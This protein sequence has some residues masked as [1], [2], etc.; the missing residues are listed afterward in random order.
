MALGLVSRQPTQRR[1]TEEPFAYYGRLSQ[2]CRPKGGNCVRSFIRSNKALP[3][4]LSSSLYLLPLPPPQPT[5]CLRPLPPPLLLPLLQHPNP[6]M[7]ML[8]PKLRLAKSDSTLVSSVR[9]FYVRIGTN[10]G[11]RHPIS[12]PRC[13]WRG[14][15]WYSVLGGAQT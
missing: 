6:S 8:L 5:L 15:I 3:C 9:S 12:G 14:R 2:L 13:S 7:H 4:S 1:G 11:F 10:S